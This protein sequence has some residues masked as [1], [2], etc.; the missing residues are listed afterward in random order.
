VREGHRFSVFCNKVF[1]EIHEL[2]RDLAIRDWRKL[3]MRSPIIST[4]LLI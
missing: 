1:M 4:F 2:M 3:H